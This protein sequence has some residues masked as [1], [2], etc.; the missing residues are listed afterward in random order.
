MVLIS[1]LTELTARGL[2][3]DIIFIMGATRIANYN[4]VKKELLQNSKS[5]G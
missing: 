3:P 2:D 4:F 5:S 1:S